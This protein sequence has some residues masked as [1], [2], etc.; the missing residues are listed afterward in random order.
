MGDLNVNYYLVPCL[1]KGILAGLWIDR[2]QSH[3]TGA[4]LEVGVTCQNCGWMGLEALDVF[5]GVCSHVPHC[6]GVVPLCRLLSLVHF[7]HLFVDCW[8][9]KSGRTLGPF[10]AKV[11]GCIWRSARHGS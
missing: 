6:V 8:P 2:E 11:W 10:K 9:L 3:V 4:G 5:F 7:V 1:F